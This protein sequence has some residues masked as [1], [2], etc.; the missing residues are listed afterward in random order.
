VPQLTLALSAMPSPRLSQAFLYPCLAFSYPNTQRSYQL[1][2]WGTGFSVPTNCPVHSHSLSLPCLGDFLHCP[3]PCPISMTSHS[4][5]QNAIA[6]KVSLLKPSLFA[7]QPILFNQCPKKWA[8][9]LVQNQ[10]LLSSG[11]RE[12]HPAI[13]DNTTTLSPDDPTSVLLY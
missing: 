11:S 9:S 8:R 12:G 10:N 13:E 5:D 1:Q 6:F 2:P 4:K 7:H 3:F